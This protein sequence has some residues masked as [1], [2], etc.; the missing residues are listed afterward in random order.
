MPNNAEHCED[1]LRRYG[2]TFS[3]LHTW[4]DEP[5]SILGASHRKY[6]HDPNTTPKEAKAIFGENAD[7]ACLDHIRLD[8][9]ESR[10]K[11]FGRTPLEGK[12]KQQISP[13]FTFGFLSFWFFVGGIFFAYLQSVW[14]RSYNISWLMAIGFFVIAFFLF[15]AFIGSSN[16]S[17]QKENP[18]FTYPIKLLNWRKVEKPFSR[19]Q[20]IKRCPKCRADYSSQHEKCPF[21]GEPQPK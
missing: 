1:S 8:E 10:R 7:N 20:I 21:C 2:K 16:Q 18:P 11:G 4:M 17:T 3:D 5:S 12:P 14:N 13:R 19:E 15:L 9:L 6:R